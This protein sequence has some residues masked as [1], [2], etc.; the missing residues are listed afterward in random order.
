MM[1]K[2]ESAGPSFAAWNE[3]TRMNLRRPSILPAAA[4]LTALLLAAIP[5]HKILADGVRVSGSL[6]ASAALSEATYIM[7]GDRGKIFMSVDG[8]TTWESVHS[9]TKSALA[10]VCFPDGRNGWAVGQSGT[11]LHSGDGGRTWAAQSAGVDAYFLDVDF[12]DRNHGIVVGAGATVL[13]TR[14]GGATW[15][16]SPFKTSTGLFENL[17]LFAAAMMDTRSICIVGDMGRIFV[18]E[19]GGN[20]WSETR[21]S[22]YD[23][24]MMMGR[25]LYAL[26]Y[27]SGTLYAAGIDSTFAFSRDRGK[28]W[29]Q[30]DTGFA[31]PDLYCIDMVGT[32]GVAAGSG[33]HVIKT[34]DGGS[35]WHP[36]QVPERIARFWLSGID[37]TRDG[38]GGVK[39]IVVGKR[40]TFG[41]VVDG[42]VIW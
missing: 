3:E 11:I 19:D 1:Y 40:G 24:Q 25:V 29:T 22:L 12:L 13:T 16:P 14:D 36:V 31:K 4:F 30:G 9:G 21:T 6:F 7:V 33:G 28:S 20:S 8:G 32:I 23:E 18:S 37:L 34:S 42:S 2:A 10:S 26:V 35:T 17:N 38:A 39:G 27:D 5:P 15:E 41:H